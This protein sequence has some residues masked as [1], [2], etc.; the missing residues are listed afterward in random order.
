MNMKHE[1]S[2]ST[3]TTILWITLAV[4]LT[5]LF[6][7]RLY[8]TFD[9]DELEAL[10]SAWYIL[11]GN[12]PYRDF[13][14]HHHPFLYYTLVPV[15]HFFGQNLHGMI[16][17]RILIFINF[18]LILLVTYFL[19]K[20]IF[21]PVSALMATVLLSGMPIFF[22]ILEIRP[23]GPQTLFGMIAVYCLVR[24]ICSVPR[25]PSSPIGL[26]P[27]YLQ[28]ERVKGPARRPVRPS[29]SEGGSLSAGGWLLASALSLAV[30]F[31]FLQKA[32]F[33]MVFIACWVWWMVYK[34][35]IA[36]WVPF[37]YALMCAIPLSAYG[38]YL[39]FSGS[40]HYY[41]RFN[42]TLNALHPARYYP[43]HSLIY[44]TTLSTVVCA[45]YLIGMRYYLCTQLQRM[46]GAL[47]IWLFFVAVCVVKF[48]Y[49]QYYAP[50]APIIALIA[51]W[52]VFQQF[53]QQTTAMALIT[54]V[55]VAG[56]ILSNTLS[57]A[58]LLARGTYN[59]QHA[60]LN[61]ILE[62]TEP[63]DYVY[64]GKSWINV[65]RPDTNFFW[66]EARMNHDKSDLIPLYEK[67]TGK[68]YDL[69]GGIDRLKPKII[70]TYYIDQT[71]PVIA[72]H[73]EPI[74]AFNDL[75]I[76]KD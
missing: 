18:L 45:F 35:Q 44:L 28:G 52:A 62:H 37:V 32:S 65:F 56:S 72:Q 33:L 3:L 30:S 10:H 49:L 46:L 1:L 16:A 34:K 24:F 60:K 75:L 64:D 11:K 7:G 76:R 25:D 43:W 63:T 38:A 12:A 27:H 29:F 42:W 40:W 8:G 2:F 74:T 57:T 4:G 47:S 17:A 53:K 15:L 68:T 73:Y 58:K 55:G 5:V 70:S 31:L 14:Q 61:Y 48:S 67:L 39:Y 50:I 9:Q 36:F 6:F 19:G 54:L 59:E 66:F 20:R 71:N 26:Q 41:Y 13:F 23:D 51:A 22:K 69:Y 21:N